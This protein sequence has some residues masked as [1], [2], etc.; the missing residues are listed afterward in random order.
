MPLRKPGPGA[1]KEQRRA[2]ASENISKLIGEGFERKRAVAAGLNSAG[3][4]RSKKK[5][6]TKKKKSNSTFE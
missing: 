2:I 6:R 3:M 5:K 4:G 1:S